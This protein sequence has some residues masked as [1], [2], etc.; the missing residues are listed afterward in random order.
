MIN[1]CAKS[2]I[3]DCPNCGAPPVDT[4]YVSPESDCYVMEGDVDCL[5]CNHAW[6]DEIPPF[7]H[8]LQ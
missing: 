3:M 5:V 7:N 8:F 1:S 6:N 4:L 2:A